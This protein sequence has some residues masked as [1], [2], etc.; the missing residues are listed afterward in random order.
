MHGSDPSHLDVEGFVTPRCSRQ[1]RNGPK[2]S[3]AVAHAI[4]A[5]N[6]MLELSHQTI[7]SALRHEPPPSPPSSARRPRRPWHR[8]WQ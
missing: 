7:R 3:G 5:E 2:A 4:R 8:Q 1:R 6:A